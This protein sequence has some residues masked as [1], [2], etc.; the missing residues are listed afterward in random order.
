M[1]SLASLRLSLL[2]L[3]GLALWLGAGAVM[4]AS[5]AFFAEFRQINQA[6][7][8][9]WALASARDSVGLAAWLAGLFALAGL[10]LTNL[11]CCIWQRLL[12]WLRRRSLPRYLSLAVHLLALG[13]TLVQG[14]SFFTGERAA[15]VRLAPGQS[16]EAF[17]GIRVKLEQIVYRSD[18]ALLKLKGRKARHAMT[19]ENFD[20]HASWAE[21]GFYKQGKELSR[22]RILYFHPARQG[23]VR[24]FLTGFFGAG[25][26]KV[27]ARINVV[28][29]PLWP[30]FAWL[31]ALLVLSLAAYTI[32]QAVGGNGQ[33]QETNR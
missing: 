23:D 19:R 7:L 16:V 29:S 8:W 20:R 10:L 15:N 13:V 11:A 3:S 4:A 12:P 31:Y 33:Q 21:I 32:R 5:S 6:N 30:L 14:A 27:G 18:P 25:K 9:Q 17:D 1:G 2:A 28:Q 26:E 22:Q 24:V